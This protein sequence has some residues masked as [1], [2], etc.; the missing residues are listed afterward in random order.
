MN[1]ITV[2]HVNHMTIWPSFIS[3]QLISLLAYFL[4]M[5]QSS[6]NLST[7]EDLDRI[8]FSL[9]YVQVPQQS[10]GDGSAED[11][12]LNLSDEDD[13]GAEEDEDGSGAEEEWLL[14]EDGSRAEEERLSDEDGSGAEEEWLSDEDGSGAEE[15]WQFEDGSAEE[16]ERPCTPP[17]PKL[18]KDIPLKIQ[19]WVRKAH[20][21]LHIELPVII[22]ALKDLVLRHTFEDMDPDKVPNFRELYRRWF[23]SDEKKYQKFVL[24]TLK[25][26]QYF[27]RKRKITYCSS[28]LECYAFVSKEEKPNT[29]WLA[30]LLFTDANYDIILQTI[31]HEITH[32]ADYTVDY[33]INEKGTFIVVEKESIFNYPVL[34]PDECQDLATQEP[35]NAITNA[36]NYGLFVNDFCKSRSR[37]DEDI[38]IDYN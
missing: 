24:S 31:T 13:S 28:D 12:W 11:E 29:I 3:L 7:D 38:N 8:L 16:D 18:S 26:C 17:S 33:R 6:N 27:L 37:S 25:N 20:N 1:G 15:E 22:E 21:E 36:D 10:D 32:L 34:S 2:S 5:S 14:D 35:Q 9:L 4:V 23:G 30:K 19:Q